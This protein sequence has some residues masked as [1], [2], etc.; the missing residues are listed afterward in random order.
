MIGRLQ[1][2]ILGTMIQYPAEIDNAAALIKSEDFTLPMYSDIFDFLVKTH[3]ADYVLLA[4]EFNKKYP[5]H[6]IVSWGDELFLPSFLRKHCQELLELRRKDF[7]YRVLVEARVEIENK[8]SAEILETINSKIMTLETKKTS[9]PVSSK[10]L[11]RQTIKTIEYRYE[12][13]GQITGL[14]YGWKDL[15]V[16]TNG[17]HSGDLIII[18]G[19]PAMGKSAIASNICENVCNL[20]KKVLQ[21]SLEMGREQ[22]TERYIASIGGLNFGRIRSGFLKD[23]DWDNLMSSAGVF[24]GFNLYIDDTPAITLAEIR[25]K[26]RAIKRQQGLDLIVVDYLQLIGM[27]S[28][29]NRVQAIGEVSRGL[30]QLARELELPVVLLS[31]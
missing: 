6:E 23:S 7:L 16:A 30:K 13:K 10:T 28:R 19:R 12:K 24:H 20:G 2:A 3:G 29:D 27:N 4:K 21:F 5:I 17:M 22:L 25:H 15:D 8:S 26:S 9:E 18:A 14:S 11:I 31:Q 1:K